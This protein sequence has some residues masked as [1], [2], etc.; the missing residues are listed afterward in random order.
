MITACSR[1][2]DNQTGCIF[3]RYSSITVHYPP[4]QEVRHLSQ[5]V[6]MHFFR[7][8]SRDALLASLSLS[9]NEETLNEGHW[10]QC[11]RHVDQTILCD[12]P[13][14]YPPSC[15]ALR[16][17]RGVWVRADSSYRACGTDRLLRILKWYRTMSCLYTYREE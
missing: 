12:T 3:A 15:N 16:H 17:P 10:D 11:A 8:H 13:A 9:P 5:V 2:D 6:S 4:S 7:N 1:L 14:S